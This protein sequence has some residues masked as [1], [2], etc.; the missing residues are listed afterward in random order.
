MPSRAQILEFLQ[1]SETIAGK[2][3][4]AKAFGLKGQ[5]K[6][7]LKA[8]LK[9]MAEEGLIDGKK[10]AYHRMGGVPKVTVLRIAEIARAHGRTLMPHSPYFGPGYFATLQ[11]ASADELALELEITIDANDEQLLKVS[12]ALDEHL[13]VGFLRRDGLYLDQLSGNRAVRAG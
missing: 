4:I 3:E 2:R 12:L 7:A 13:V 10:T 11:L 1:S 5:E 8:L 6:I 9:D